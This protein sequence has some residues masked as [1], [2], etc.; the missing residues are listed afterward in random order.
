MPDRSKNE[1]PRVQI[2]EIDAEQAGQRLDNF[3]LA[4]LKGVP[5]SL[6]YRIVRGG[7]V[8]LNGKRVRPE[9]RLENGD[10]IRIPPVRLADR[11]SAVP[12]KGLIE[13]LASRI[14]Y[15]DEGLLVIDKP[16]GLAVHGGSGLSLGL[17]EALRAMRSEARSLEL[18]HR[19]DRDTS[20]CV[21]IAKKRATLRHLHAALRDGTITKTYMTLVQGSWSKRRTRVSISL[22]KNTVR[23][24]ERVVRADESG[25]ASETR[26]RVLRVFR[27]ASLLEAQPVTGRTHQIRVHAQVSGHPVAGDGKYGDREFN[28]RMTDFGLRRLFLHASSLSFLLPDGRPLEVS[29]PLDAALL[30]VLA[31]LEQ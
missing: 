7:E 5:R 24:G 15:E 21:L 14:V 3:L 20:G 12:G 17:I 30:D 27:E 29:A 13:T 9:Q 4:R 8:R 19:L 6:V 31:R 26:F 11:P 1:Q 2:V 16:S 23:S 25:K 22:E 10:R 18:V 28:R